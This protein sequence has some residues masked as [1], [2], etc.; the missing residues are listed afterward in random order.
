MLALALSDPMAFARQWHRSEGE[1]GIFEHIAISDFRGLEASDELSGTTIDQ[2]AFIRLFYLVAK[3][4]EFGNDESDLDIFG[5]QCLS[6]HLLAS[7]Q[8]IIGDR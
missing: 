2:A 3:C 4:I 5:C 7:L 8:I 6:E 1:F